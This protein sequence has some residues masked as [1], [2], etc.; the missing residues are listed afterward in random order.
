MRHCLAA[1]ALAAASVSPAHAVEL[2]GGIGLP[3]ATIGIAQPLE[4][5]PVTL[6]ADWT[7]IGDRTSD[8]VEEGIAYE[9]K[10]KANRVGLFADWFAFGGVFRFTAGLTSNDYRLNLSATGAGG[11]LTIGDTTYTTTSADRFDVAVKFPRTT[12]YLGIGWGHHA[13][14]GFRFS[15]DIGVMIGKAKLTTAVSGPAA[16]RVSQADIDKETAEL[17]DGVARVRV[18][19]QIGIAIGYSF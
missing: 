5:S 1:A 17:R 18:V 2:Y 7:T 8:T 10:L 3:G 13:G 15:A 12:P 19:P 11:T 9:A 14:S 6:R 4:G 16:Q